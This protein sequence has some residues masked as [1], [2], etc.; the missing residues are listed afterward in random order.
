MSVDEA[1]DAY[2]LKLTEDSRD[3]VYWNPIMLP[4]FMA[5]INSLFE[6]N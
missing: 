6:G 2:G 3:Y 4:V 5:T 1:N